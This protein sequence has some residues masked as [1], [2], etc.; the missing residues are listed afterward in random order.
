MSAVA[1]VPYDIAVIGLGINGAHQVTREA[2]ET[3]R[4]CRRIFAA[5]TAPGVLEYLRTL[6]PDVTDLSGH[7]QPG[8]H[9]A[10]I[11]QAI[12]AD[13][14][15]AALE[16]SPVCFATYG[17]PKMYSYPTVLIQRAA[18]VLDLRVQLI[19][20]ISFLDNLLVDLSVDPGFD[21]L[22]LYEATDLL[23]RRRPLQSDVACVITQASVVANPTEGRAAD[24]ATMLARLQDY[25]LG[26]YPPDHTVVLVTSRIHPLL[27]PLLY[28]TRLRT[29]ASALASASY[30][31]TLYIP[32]VQRRDI[33]DKELADRMR[34]TRD[35]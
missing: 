3:L 9:R 31:G 4:R 6:T 19:A 21:G 17:H 26:F 8:V 27:D 15:A 24:S 13:V 12:A 22:H 16:D 23:V 11:Y 1:T 35:G 28:R 10:S 30:S 25:L 20:G 29:L 33:A 5:D 32:P 7:F 18:A 2:E 14:V 34:S